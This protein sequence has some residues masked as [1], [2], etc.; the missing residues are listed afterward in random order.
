M[1]NIQDLKY[2][3]Y[4]KNYL[5]EQEMDEEMPVQAAPKDPIYSFLFID[6]DD[7]G[8]YKYP[9][10][11]ST[12]NYTTYTITKSELDKWIN[13]NISALKDKDLSD[14]SARIKRD[15][16]FDY[17]TGNKNQVTPDDKAIIRS[18]RNN[19]ISELIGKKTKD[20]EITF[21]S[22]KENGPL[23]D[24]ME[25]TFIEIEKEK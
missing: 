7:T 19:V 4:Y 10:G 22:K 6:K 5:I 8:T 25:V 11:S 9:D 1:S 21:P 13:S 15:S 3:K 12:S 17:I 14:N 2:I 16:I 24:E 18:F 20:T 23:T